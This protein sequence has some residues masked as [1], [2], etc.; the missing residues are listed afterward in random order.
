MA[1]Y[2]HDVFK[3][4]LQRNVCFRIRKEE[5]IVEITPILSYVLSLQGK[6][7]TSIRKGYKVR[8]IT[9][10]PIHRRFQ[11]ESSILSFLVTQHF[12]EKDAFEL[13]DIQERY[14]TYEE[15]LDAIQFDSLSMEGLLDYYHDATMFSLTTPYQ[16]EY[17]NEHPYGIYSISPNDAKRAYQ[18]VQQ[19]GLSQLA[20]YYEMF[21]EEE[22]QSLPPYE[23]LL[24][25]IEEETREHWD[26]VVHQLLP[27]EDSP[28]IHDQMMMGKTR[29]HK[30][31]ALWHFYH[32]YSMMVSTYQV[33][34]EAMQQ[35]TMKKDLHAIFLNPLYAPLKTSLIKTEITFSW[36]C[37]TSSQLSIVY[38]F[39]WND[40]TKHWL[41]QFKN[42][43]ELRTTEDLAFYRNDTL[44]FSSCTHEGFHVD[45]RD[46]AKI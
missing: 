46:M 28:F 3:D 15:Y 23:Q 34:L 6:E 7:A 43:Y 40:A 44:L 38:Y 1:Q 27:P 14:H 33:A 17:S 37:T 18:N 11:K 5:D 9:S 36:H 25:T 29:F 26:R 39:A 12:M 10:N 24:Q 22:K 13:L 42:D 19:E 32:H 16:D 41:Q 30:P 8:R 35:N 20:Q 4:L 45:C 2:S 31:Q 21:T